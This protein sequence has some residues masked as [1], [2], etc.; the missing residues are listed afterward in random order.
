MTA[1]DLIEKLRE[2]PSDGEVGWTRIGSKTVLVIKGHELDPICQL[3]NLQADKPQSA[4][5]R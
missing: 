2:F 3:D 4:T 5:S 1:S